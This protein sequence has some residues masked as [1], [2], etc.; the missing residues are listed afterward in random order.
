MDNLQ[1]TKSTLARLLA[2]ENLNIDIRKAETASFNTKT[3]TLTLPLWEDT[4]P[5][6]YDL[7][8]GHEVGHALDTPEEGWHDAV[9]ENMKPGFKTFL[10]VVEDARIER[11]IKTRYPGIRKSFGIGYRELNERDFFS[12]KGK[13]INGFLLID[14]INMHFKLGVSA[15]VQ[16]NAEEQYFVDKV[17]DTETFED[18]YQVAKEL[19]EYCQQEMKDKLEQAPEPSPG[20]PGEGEDSDSI[21][22]PFQDDS[23]GNGESADGNQMR[24][25]D[26]DSNGGSSNDD[27]GEGEDEDSSDIT[28]G[29]DS[30]PND[31]KANPLTSYDPKSVTDESFQN[32]VK[33]LSS[34]DGEILTGKIP[35]NTAFEPFVH[36]KELINRI[37]YEEAPNSNMRYLKEFE[38]KNKNAL[39]YLVKEFEM[40]K[41]AAELRR[42]SVAQTGQLD[43]NKLHTYKFN[44]DIFRRVANV[45][46]GKNHGLFL[47]LDWSGSMGD[48]LKGTVE[49]LITL[50]QFCKK[51][52]VP[53]E[54]VAFSSEYGRSDQQISTFT[55]GEI[56][57][58][59][60]RLLNFLSSTMPDRVYRKQCADMLA[61]VSYY[62]GIAINDRSLG[63]GST[64]LNTTIMILPK[65]IN[66][67]R[68]KHRLQIVNTIFLTDGEDSSGIRVYGDNGRIKHHMSQSTANRDC[69]IIDQETKK[70]YKIPAKANAVTPTL[71]KILKDKTGCNL[72]GFYITNNYR[73][74]FTNVMVQLTGDLRYDRNSDYNFADGEFRKWKEDKVSVVNNWGF[75]EYYIIPGGTSLHVKDDD[76]DE[77]IGET[78]ASARKL[79]GAFLKMNQNRLTNRVLLKKFIE[80]VS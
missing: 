34:N 44:D 80:R 65:Y 12:I 73:S 2:T 54:V 32:K 17:A 37:A 61:A 68:A 13:D 56:S 18:V 9:M 20:E 19:Y 78:K 6:L 52:G 64:P 55:S 8:V 26:Q 31:T 15:D 10:N 35:K 70:T 62:R 77:L 72:I 63:L 28:S 67:F 49:Q 30:G 69:I 25:T 22:D 50:T 51:V 36:W 43:T 1:T 27:V 60:T 14:R 53:F 79:R 41:K 11:K 59:N 74:N 75:D 23:E 40:R 4:S 7:L 3:R 39:M 76:L 46:Q 16:F 5:E 58:D 21:G 48:H 66:A 29:K 42:V 24:E 47:I 33:K 57:L 71:L 45:S 38:A